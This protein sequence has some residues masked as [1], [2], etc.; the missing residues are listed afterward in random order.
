VLVTDLEELMGAQEDPT[1]KARRVWE[2]LAPRY[3]RDIQFWERV[4]FGGGR[5]WVCSRATG[6]VLEVAVGT[7]RNFPFYPADVT[8]TGVELS[9]AMLALA[10]ERA[11]DL[12]R[13]VDLHEGNAESLPFVDAQFD[14]VVCTI[15]LC[16]VH[17]PE[18][19]IAEMRRV[20][21]PGGRLL[22]LDHIGSS[23]WP[24]WAAQR[25]V[26][27]ITIRTAG[28]HMTRRQLP[29]VEAA[30]FEIVERQRL[31]AGTVERI[32]ARKPA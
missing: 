11:S 27:L 26:E 15:S 31:K 19:A 22:L 32:S 16:G 29:L 5:E 3:D 6:N 17:R 14:S 10:R 20:L 12:G 9:P 25:L 4:Q 28:E 24:V 13:P 30:G 21:H 1:S 8:I 2:Q 7:G 18:Q 23:W